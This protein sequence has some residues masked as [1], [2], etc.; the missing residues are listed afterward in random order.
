MYCL[1][2]KVCL[3][4]ILSIR[5]YVDIWE[6]TTTSSLCINAVLS[7]HHGYTQP[8][9]KKNYIK[10][11]LASTSTQCP[12]GIMGAHNQNIK[13]KSHYND[14]FLVAAVQTLLRQH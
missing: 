3:R 14:L 6:I 2:K 1:D 7:W 8:K 13:K 12:H 11:H 4:K 5:V 9:N 10:D